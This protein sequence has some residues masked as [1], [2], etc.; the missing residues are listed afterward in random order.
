MKSV[1][2]SVKFGRKKLAILGIPLEPSET[3]GH[4]DLLRSKTKNL[5]LID[6][7]KKSYTFV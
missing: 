3:S 1:Y 2:S 7:F 5:A 4:L 6:R